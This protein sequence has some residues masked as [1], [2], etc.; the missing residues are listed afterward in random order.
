MKLHQPIS[1]ILVAILA[2]ACAT[3]PMAPRSPV[4]PAPG[5]PFEVFAAE[6]R[7]CR[8]YAE[9]S[10]EHPTQAANDAAVSSAAV[11][12]VVGAVI[13]AA[14][15]GRQGAAVGAG[16][17]LL[18]GSA[19]GADNAYATERDI[20]RRYDIAFQQCMYSKGN[21]VTGYQY[22]QPAA[23]VPPPPPG[24]GSVPPPPPSG[25]YPPPPPGSGAYPPPP[26]PPA[27]SAPPPPPGVR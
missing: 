12:T 20:H 13:G 19:S 27:G 14:V 11:G 16:T 21:Q 8:Q 9:Q 3:R 5:K 7:S 2:S 6:E 25:A 22:A 23:H 1:V 4:M 17:G 15:G 26:P 10:V 18:F 24:S